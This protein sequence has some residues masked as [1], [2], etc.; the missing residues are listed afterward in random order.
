[1]RNALVKHLR[2][3][4]LEL[5]QNLTK[6]E[7]EEA[8]IKHRLRQTQEGLA[9]I[10]RLLDLEGVPIPVSPRPP[11]SGGTKKMRLGDATYEILVE[12]GAPVHYRELVRLLS[13]RGVAVGG[14]DP[15]GN[16]IAHLHGDPRFQRTGRGTYT[17][18]GSM[19]GV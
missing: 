4:R 13:Q 9:A 7:A 19:G 11:A 6:L 17:V 14:K 1:M 16:L 2:Q 15:G 5:Q 3:R 12:R 18:N 10:D 8:D